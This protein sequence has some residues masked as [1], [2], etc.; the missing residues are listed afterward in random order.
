[1]RRVIWYFLL[2]HTLVE[3]ISWTWHC[4]SRVWQNCTDQSRWLRDFYGQ[5][6]PMASRNC[7]YRSQDFNCKNSQLN[8][9]ISGIDSDIELSVR[10][11]SNGGSYFTISVQRAGLSHSF[12]R[13]WDNTFPYDGA[14]DWFS[15]FPYC[16]RTFN[17]RCNCYSTFFSCP[18]GC[19]KNEV[20]CYVW[21]WR[22]ILQARVSSQL[23][24]N[25]V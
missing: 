12:V 6:W 15:Q 20:F 24:L 2:A 13:C 19:I 14:R 4:V 11:V 21:N 23:C 7:A 18:N 22:T 25:H 3:L 16:N 5:P 1:M 9:K 17:Y 10:R 8:Y